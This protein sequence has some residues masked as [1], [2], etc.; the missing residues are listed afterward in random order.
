MWSA[1]FCPIPRVVVYF[2]LYMIF[3]MKGDGSVEAS[4][5]FF[6]IEKTLEEL[7]K[8]LFILNDWNL[9]IYDMFF[10]F[11][12]YGD[13][14]WNY[15]EKGVVKLSKNVAYEELLQKVYSKFGK[16]YK[17]RDYA[18]KDIEDWMDVPI[19][20]VKEDL[21]Y[22]H[23]IIRTSGDQVHWGFQVDEIR[24]NS[25]RFGLNIQIVEIEVVEYIK[26]NDIAL[27]DRMIEMY[28]GHYERYY[29]YFGVPIPIQP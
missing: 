17:K 7:E 24:S 23:L 26:K 21:G 3:N 9:K 4:I 5:R 2:Y 28:K 25:S 13:G 1:F 11:L 20:L 10:E 15:S 18:Y 8:E 19:N 6:N 12:Y 29:E 14:M 16:T 22:E 27:R